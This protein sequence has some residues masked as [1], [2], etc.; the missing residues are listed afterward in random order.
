MQIY[1]EV[2]VQL[3]A[4]LTS[5]TNILLTLTGKLKGQ[6]VPAVALL[7]YC[8]FYLVC[9]NKYN[10]IFGRRRATEENMTTIYR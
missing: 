2:E 10:A 1:E 4:F 5:L 7:L 6:Q 8:R 3:H 9:L